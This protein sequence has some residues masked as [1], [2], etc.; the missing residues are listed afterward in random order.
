MAGMQVVVVDC[1]EKEMS[2]LM[3]SERKLRITVII[4]QLL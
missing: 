2:M 1:D 4:L 3:I